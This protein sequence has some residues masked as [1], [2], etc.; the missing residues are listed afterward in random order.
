MRTL[1]Y[2]DIL[3]SGNLAIN[4]HNQNIETL[5][6]QDVSEIIRSIHMFDYYSIEIT[7]DS[8][9]QFIDWKFENEFNY[10]EENNEYWITKTF[11]LENIIDGSDDFEISISTNKKY[12]DSDVKIKI[13]GIEIP[14]KSNYFHDLQNLFFLTTG[15]KLPIKKQYIND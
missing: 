2:N 13:D 15:Q 4:T 10:H 1:E 3:T 8:I 14:M 5:T 9:Y 12:Q 7:E 11:I 6:S